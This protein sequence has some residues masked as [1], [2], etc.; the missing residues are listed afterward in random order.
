MDGFELVAAERNLRRKI[1]ETA[2]NLSVDLVTAE[3][4]RALR[5]HDVRSI[6][7]KGPSFAGWLYPDGD[8]RLYADVDLLLARK[9]LPTA[10]TVLAGLGFRQISESLTYFVRD[11]DQVDL[12]CSLKGAEAG[13]ERVWTVL[14]ETSE[15]QDVGGLEVEILI[16]P[17]RALHVALH[18][19]QHGSEWRTPMEDLRRALRMLPFASWE[20]ARDLAR[21]LEATPAFATGL[22]LLPDGETLADRLNLDMEASVETVLRATSP[23]HLARGFAELHAIRGLRAKLRFVARKLFPPHAYVAI[24]WPRAERGRLWLLFAYCQRLIWLIRNS[25][26]GFRAWMTARREAKIRRG[27]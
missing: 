14:S 10:R 4:V 13:D 16:P 20:E 2:G 23:P 26:P 8:V 27:E 21:R 5:K 24:D 12:H 18:A 9:D 1:L 15:A 25:R 17:A 11:D 7:L 22:R 19:A 3:V 6:L